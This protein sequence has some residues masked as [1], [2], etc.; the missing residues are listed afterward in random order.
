MAVFLQHTF[1]NKYEIEKY[2][3]TIT[4]WRCTRPTRRL[5]PQPRPSR[6]VFRG[7]WVGV[8]LK[9]SPF[10]LHQLWLL[11]NHI[12]HLALAQNNFLYSHINT[13]RNTA[14][15]CQFTFSLNFRKPKRWIQSNR[16]ELTSGMENRVRTSDTATVASSSWPLGRSRADWTAKRKRNAHK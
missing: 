2:T 3:N 12:H 14:G 4:L 10:L 8:Q 6:I 11:V 16:A 13:I 5:S 7:G 9:L 1:H 15:E